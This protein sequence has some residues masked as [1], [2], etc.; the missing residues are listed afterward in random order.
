LMRSAIAGRLRD[1]AGFWGRCDETLRALKR[2]TIAQSEVLRFLCTE[3]GL[4]R[5]ASILQG[6]FVGLRL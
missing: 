5:G 1:A 3:F 4:A 6:R 2:T